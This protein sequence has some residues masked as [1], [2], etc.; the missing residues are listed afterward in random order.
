[1]SDIN[2]IEMAVNVL[3]KSGLAKKNLT[4]LHCNTEYPVPMIEVNLRAMV[5]IREAFGV[6]VGLSDHTEGIEIA[7]AAVALGATVIEKHI[8]LDHN[9]PG[10]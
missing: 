4:I 8:T 7:I 5:S 10:P 9:L 1:M 3:Y 6:E 2:E